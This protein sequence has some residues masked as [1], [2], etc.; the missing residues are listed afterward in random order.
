MLL[1][2]SLWSTVPLFF[3]NCRRITYA[4]AQVH[5]LLLSGISF[6]RI[7]PQSAAICINETTMAFP[8]PTFT[9]TILCLLSGLATVSA[10][11]HNADGC[12]CYRTNESSVGY[13]TSHRF[14]DYRNASPAPSSVPSII[15]NPKSAT[16]AYATSDF[17]LGD[18]WTS[19]WTTQKF[20]NS[21]TRHSTDATT[22]M[23]N[24]PNNVYIGSIPLPIKLP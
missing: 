14:L 13:F 9:A 22:M 20:N 11:S 4:A 17:F 24:S 18:A 21:E 23:V 3:Y 15:S 19:F 2:P 5:L 8:L 10:Q 12:S 6:H 1:Y 7:F 16:D